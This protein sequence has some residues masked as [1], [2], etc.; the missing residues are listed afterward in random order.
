MTKRVINVFED[1]ND[2]SVP[3]VVYITRILDEATIDYA[4]FDPSGNYDLAGLKKMMADDVESEY[5]T[6]NFSYSR[7]QAERLSKFTYY[8][9]RSLAGE[10]KKIIERRHQRMRTAQPMR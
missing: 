6:F 1:Q 8:T 3:T 5:T 10:L 9:V 7:A 4:A 2:I